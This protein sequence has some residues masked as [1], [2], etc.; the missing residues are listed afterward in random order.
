MIK[1]NLNIMHEKK[2]N[3]TWTNE[4]VQKRIQQKEPGHYTWKKQI[5]H[6]QKIIQKKKQIIHGKNQPEHYTWKKKQIIHGHKFVQQ[7][8][9]IHVKKKSITLYM[10]K[11][12]IIPE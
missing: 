6:G 9:I 4:I 3:H 12:T 1:P 7:K 11:K 2:P 10:T 5:I 8:Q